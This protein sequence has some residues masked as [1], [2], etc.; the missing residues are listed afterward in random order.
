[1]GEADADRVLTVTLRDVSLKLTLS[2]KL[3]AKSLNHACVKPFLAAYAKKAGL[4]TP[5]RVDDIVE[6]VVDGATVDASEVAGG[7]LP[8]KQ[9]GIQ[10]ELRLERGA[11]GPIAQAAPVKIA[12]ALDTA[13]A[14]P[15]SQPTVPGPAAP[16]PTPAAPVPTPA[17]GVLVPATSAQPATLASSEADLEQDWREAAANL[18]ALP[19]TATEAALSSL[20]EPEHRLEDSV[21]QREVGDS[22][23]VALASQVATATFTIDLGRGASVRACVYTLRPSKSGGAY[24]S[25][26]L[27]LVLI[28]HPAF[29][30]ARGPLVLWQAYRLVLEWRC[31]VCAIDYLPHHGVRTPL[32]SGQGAQGA[33]HA[34]WP[35][36][37]LAD[38]GD[39][40]PWA[41]ENWRPTVARIATEWRT[42]LDVLLAAPAPSGTGHAFDGEMEAS[43][44]R[45]ATERRS[46]LGSMEGYG[47]G[48]LV[49]ADKVGI[50]GYSSGAVAAF[51]TLGIEQRT[52]G[53]I[54]AAVLAGVSDV[55]LPIG[56]GSLPT[57]N[58]AEF[59]ARLR[60]EAER[61][62]VSLLWVANEEDA[63]S[64]IGRVRELF[65]AVG[66]KRKTLRVLPGGHCDLSV[67]EI[68]S[69]E[70]W[71]FDQLLNK[72][73]EAEADELGDSQDVH[74]ID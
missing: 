19:G 48:R 57:P 32:G 16:M 72:K 22:R 50:L 62:R 59:A 30:H 20:N 10:V 6:V 14:P 26:G 15:R 39:A 66:S 37:H 56:P 54:S 7:V 33:R 5:H 70:E 68:L 3:L 9:D 2:P 1:M 55:F 69:H 53:R 63:K 61:V 29:H 8:V 58:P 23:A 52:K 73:V 36:R 45:L 31:V 25:N 34:K 38:D 28:A 51:L 44:R 18:F 40:A 21:G 4:E 43:L 60:Q 49:A 47:S 13:N 11:A 71:M 67:G 27:P 35:A 24:P 12:N 41:E 65:E 64:P 17:P 46:V 74:E 42:A